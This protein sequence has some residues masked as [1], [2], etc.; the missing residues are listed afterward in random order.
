MAVIDAKD[1]GPL[2]PWVVRSAAHG[3]LRHQLKVGDRL[4]TVTHTCA[5]TVRTGITTTDHNDVFSSGS[6]EVL[7]LPL[8]FQRAFFGHEQSLLVRR[9]E[10]HG[11]VNAFEVSSWNRQITG[12]GS[13]HAKRNGVV[14]CT[15]F[16]HINVSSNIGVRDKLDTFLAQQVDTT[17]D[18]FLF[19]LHVGDTVHEKTTDAISTFVDGDLVSHLIQL[20]C[21]CQSSRTRSNHR[22][23]HPRAFLGDA[24]RNVPI[25]PGFV[26][27]GIFNVLDGDG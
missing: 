15:Q 26:H 5:N 11:K 9:Q 25:L 21:G 3:W 23:R 14:I 6:D 22:D 24:R 12:L 2:R 4:A 18:R 20:I 10:F 16:V 19:Q 13:T 1:T 7:L 17:L 27:N 8:G